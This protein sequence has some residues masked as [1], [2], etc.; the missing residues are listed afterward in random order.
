[1]T[2]DD[3]DLLLDDMKRLYSIRNDIKHASNVEDNYSGVQRKIELEEL[4]KSSEN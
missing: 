2:T 1:M 4:A 3:T